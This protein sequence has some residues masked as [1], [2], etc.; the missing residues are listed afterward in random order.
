MSEAGV[1]GAGC[2]RLLQEGL[3]E[4]GSVIC[5]VPAEVFLG[6][7]LPALVFDSFSD[8]VIALKV[9]LLRKLVTF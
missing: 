1:A 5:T 6:R 7:R 4:S 3:K 2:S 9:A 8:A